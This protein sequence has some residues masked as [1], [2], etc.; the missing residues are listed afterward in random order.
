M[1]A[2]ASCNLEA[3]RLSQTKEPAQVADDD[4]LP[5]TLPDAPSPVVEVADSPQE[6]IEKNWKASC[7]N[8]L[9][10]V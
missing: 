1:Y 3:L 9:M 2:E 7:L 10:I 4:T 6:S 5:A 8:S